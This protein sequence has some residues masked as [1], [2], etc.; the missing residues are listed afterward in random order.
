MR[1]NAMADFKTATLLFWAVTMVSA[2]VQTSQTP[3]GLK[4]RMQALIYRIPNTAAPKTCPIPSSEDEKNYDPRSISIDAGSK[5]RLQQISFAHNKAIVDQ[6]LLRLQFS[7]KDGDVYDSDS[8]AK[9]LSYLRHGYASLGYIDF[10]VVPHISI[11]EKKR[12]I[13]LEI[14]FNE[15]QQFFVNRIDII[16]LDEPAFQKIKTQVMLEPGQLYNQRLMEFFL[17]KHSKKFLKHVASAP[18][19]SLQRNELNATVAITYDFRQ[20]PAK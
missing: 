12:T 9:D 6:R 7:I 17:K 3:E 20:C 15:G 14:F 11:N 10:T 4:Q 5:Y 19:F 2:Q 8:I 16:G 13:A 1:I 18:S